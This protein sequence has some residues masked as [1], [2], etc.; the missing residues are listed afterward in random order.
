MQLEKGDIWRI[1]NETD[2]FI[3][4]TN[5]TLKKDYRLVMGRGL[6]KQIRDRIPGIDLELG[7]RILLGRHYTTSQQFYLVNYL[8][9]L[10]PR[11]PAV[12]A[13]QVKEHYESPAKLE[14]ITG[15]TQVLI[16]LALS[17]KDKRFDMNFPGIG[18]GQLERDV[19]LPI[20]VNLP[21]NVHVW[22][23]G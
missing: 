19:V 5:A 7:T 23:F 20:I 12:G 6:A 4:T 15:A 21:D 1:V 18:N 17:F 11:T 13:F 16:D 8:F 9:V 22:E 2:V 3:V 10:V 14:L